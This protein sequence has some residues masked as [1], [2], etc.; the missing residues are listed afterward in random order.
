[1]QRTN[2]I[3]VLSQ[4]KQEKDLQIDTVE[5]ISREPS[6]Y[7]MLDEK[8]FQKIFSMLKSKLGCNHMRECL[9][10]LETYQTEQIKQT[11]QMMRNIQSRDERNQVQ[12]TLNQMNKELLQIQFRR[13]NGSITDKLLVRQVCTHYKNCEYCVDL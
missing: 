7:D 6:D 3:K 12:I 1:M 5:R 10:C 11:N 9:D 13:W 8:K 2:D 4:K